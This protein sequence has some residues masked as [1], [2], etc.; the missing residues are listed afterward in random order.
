MEVQTPEG[1]DEALRRFQG[2]GT[3]DGGG[4]SSGT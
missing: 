3:D 2:V 4:E 1:F